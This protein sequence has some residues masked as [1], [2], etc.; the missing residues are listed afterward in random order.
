ML[1]RAIYDYYGLHAGELH[2][3]GKYQS[4][5]LR[6]KIYVLVPIRELKED[7]LLEIKNL[8]DF[9][10][11]CGDTTVGEFVENMYGY[12]VSKINGKDCVLLKY[13]RSTPREVLPMGQELAQF[14]FQGKYYTE[15]IEN[16]NRIG[17]W[18][19]LWVSRLEQLE[20]F[21]REKVMTHP[22]SGVDRDFVDTFPYY[23][24]LTENA[25]QYVVDT[26]MDDEPKLFD[27]GTV[28]YNHFTRQQWD[29]EYRM[30]M[31]IEWVYDHPSRDIAEFIRYEFYHRKERREEVILEFLN[32]YEKITPLSSFS[33]RLIY[34][35]LLFP[36]PYFEAIEG[37]YGS[38]ASGR[39]KYEKDLKACIDLLP[40]Y[41]DFLKR[42]YSLIK[43]P[44]RK[45]G[46]RDIEWLS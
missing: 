16:I 22:E 21:W 26:E 43:L 42:F 30:K 3:W 2:Q 35:R 29:N 15:R 32:E 9:Y 44:T 34:G 27:A 10:N 40:A 11:Q 37:Y 18:K 8:T 12:Y 5:L 45:V 14:H 23:L 19:E 25:V 1:M 41:E 7:E 39:N 13:N 36:L 17:Q 4:F 31:P 24:A 6:N 38:G 46:I 33:W 20:K 28:C